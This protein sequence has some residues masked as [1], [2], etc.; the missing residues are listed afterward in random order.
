[1]TIGTAMVA[2]TKVRTTGVSGRSQSPRARLRMV[3][4]GK[5][6][7]QIMRAS[8]CLVGGPATGANGQ[9]AVGG[10]GGHDQLLGCVPGESGREAQIEGVKG[11]ADVIVREV[12]V[13]GDGG[14][15]TGAGG[16]DDLGARVNDI[17]GG[18]HPR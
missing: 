12:A 14:C 5:T 1:M 18:P 2:S 6:A 9:A 4:V 10:W 7:T 17:A 8:S 13:Q 3:R 16:G 15:R 11:V